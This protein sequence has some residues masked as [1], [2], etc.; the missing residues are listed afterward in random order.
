MDAVSAYLRSR[1][2]REQVSKTLES[3]WNEFYIWCDSRIRRFASSYRSQVVD[4]DDCAQ[5]TWTEL[6]SRLKTFR[7]DESRGKFT[8]WLYALVRNKA[9]DLSRAANRQRATSLD[10]PAINALPPSQ[11]PTPLEELS[12]K[13]DRR[14]VRQAVE[15][16]RDRVSAGSYELVKLRWIDQRPLAE[17]KARLG[18]TANQLWVREHRLREKLRSVLEANYG[19]GKER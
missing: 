9:A 6:T 10:S 14:S 12:Q 5:E 16:L 7:L 3:S 1:S 17:V 19:I 18:I 8:S 13:L 4:V 15:H 2:A 11:Y